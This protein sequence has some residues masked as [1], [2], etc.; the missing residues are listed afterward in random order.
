MTA[1]ADFTQS[2]TWAIETTLKEHWAGLNIDLQLADIEMIGSD[3]YQFS[4]RLSAVRHRQ[5]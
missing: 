2:E 3:R 5:N 4:P 1:A